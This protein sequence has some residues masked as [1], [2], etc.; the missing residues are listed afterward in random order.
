MLFQ[1]LLCQ[2]VSELGVAI[3]GNIQGGVD[4][5]YQLIIPLMQ[6]SIINQTYT[7]NEY[8]VVLLIISIKIFINKLS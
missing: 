8:R 4:N 3:C 2:S 6:Q 5:K 7:C 1:L